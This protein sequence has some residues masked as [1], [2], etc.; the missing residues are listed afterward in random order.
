MKFETSEP[1]LLSKCIY[2]LP[3]CDHKL[4]KVKIRYGTSLETLH[5]IIDNILENQIVYYLE[6]FSLKTPP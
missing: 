3:N 5:F 2:G 4:N 6:K 1:R